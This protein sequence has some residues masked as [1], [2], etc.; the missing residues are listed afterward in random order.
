M[1]SP[2]NGVSTL[3]IIEIQKHILGIER[4]NSAYKI[5]AADVSSA[6]IQAVTVEKIYTIAGPELGT[7]QGTTPTT[8][9]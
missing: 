1:D 6:Y 4:L 9:I 5:I 7:N 3:D 2:L 8:L